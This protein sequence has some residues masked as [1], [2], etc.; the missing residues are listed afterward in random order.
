MTNASNSSRNDVPILRR[1]REWAAHFMM[2]TRGLFSDS[3]FSQ[4]FVEIEEYRAKLAAYA[5]TDLAAARVL[6]IGFGPRPNRLIALISMG[7]DARGVDI[8]Q[9]VLQGSMRE[10]LSVYRRNGSQ[11]ALKSFVRHFLFDWHERGQLSAA[12]ARRGHALR[13]D[14]SRFIVESAASSRL[15]ALFEPR[16]LDFIFAEDVFEHVPPDDLRSTLAKMHHWLR[17]GGLA[18]VRPAIFTG[19]SGGHLVDW[20]PHT[21]DADIARES[22]PWEHLRRN[23]IVA[24]TYLNK[25]RLHEYRALFLRKFDILEET[26]REPGL[27]RKFLTPAVRQELAAYTE[28]ELLTNEV[29]FV[30]RPRII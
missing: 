30:L 7:I 24:N 21:L 14:P 11:R 17:P 18:L 15:D 12:L 20:Y 9:P 6:E 22:E 19:I 10:I 3:D 1:C 26:A 5:A 13:I 2:R 16:S 29:L 8:D 28:E 25:L 23:R 4:L 27:G